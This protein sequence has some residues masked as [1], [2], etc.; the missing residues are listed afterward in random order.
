MGVSIGEG[1]QSSSW[2]DCRQM[3][4][5]KENCV[6]WTFHEISPFSCDFFSK[7]DSIAPKDFAVTG[8]MNCTDP[9]AVMVK[10]EGLNSRDIIPEEEKCI[11]KGVKIKGRQRKLR[12]KGQGIETF[13]ECQKACQENDLCNGWSFNKKTKVC[14]LFSELKTDEDS[15]KLKK[16]FISGTKNCTSPPSNSTFHGNMYE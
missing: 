6:A 3:C 7:L 14:K 2:E 11:M 4:G 15:K 5:N 8:Q 13:E 9:N 16:K 1:R 12:N 10:N